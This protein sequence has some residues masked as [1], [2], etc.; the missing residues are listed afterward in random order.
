MNARSQF[1]NQTG[2]TLIELLVVISIIGILI[3]LVL[4][5]VHRVERAATSMA[6]YPRLEGLATQI[7]QFNQAAESNAQ[8]FIMGV[9]TD[10]GTANDSDTTEVNLGALRYFCDAD[11]N[12]IGL[13]NQVNGLLGAKGGTTDLRL[14]RDESS[15]EQ[16]LL[17]ET[18]H[19]LDKEL[20][21]V[22]KLA[23]L[24]RSKASSLCS[25]TTR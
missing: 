8:A 9:A 13:Q 19:A 18:K 3:G 11:T 7:H 12:L 22:Q 25:S 4:P 6:E 14:F 15:D 1:R 5:A 10:A 20:P 2:F 21:A 24:L 23:E 17:T 16:R